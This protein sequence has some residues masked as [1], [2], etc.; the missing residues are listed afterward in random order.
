VNGSINHKISDIFQRYGL[1]QHV[2][3]A[4]HVS[5]HV[6]DLMVTPDDRQPAITAISTVSVF[7]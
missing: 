5:G 7:F 2:D 4:T 1:T 6:L 3:V